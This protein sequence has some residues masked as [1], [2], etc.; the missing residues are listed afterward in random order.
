MIIE[1]GKAFSDE[2]C[3]SLQRT[4]LRA[5]VCEPKRVFR[6]A[7]IAAKNRLQRIRPKGELCEAYE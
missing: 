2:V 1:K 4:P 5:H 6:H 3:G 7:H